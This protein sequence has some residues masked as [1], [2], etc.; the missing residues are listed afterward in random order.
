MTSTGIKLLMDKRGKEQITF[1]D[2]AD[3]LED[4]VEQHPEEND[5]VDKVAR[6][7]AAVED[8]EHD[9]QAQ[10]IGSDA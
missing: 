3:H 10:E 7:L 4:Y 9:H 2:V 1:A 8:D 5:V 6:F